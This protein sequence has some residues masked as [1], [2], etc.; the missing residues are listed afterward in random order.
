MNYDI[1]VKCKRALH[2]GPTSSGS[3]IT[4]CEYAT[5]RLTKKIKIP[6]KPNKKKMGKEAAKLILLNAYGVVIDLHSEGKTLKGLFTS[7]NFMVS[8]RTKRVALCGIEAQAYVKGDGTLDKTQFVAMVKGMY[9]D[10]LPVDIAIWLRCIEEDGHDNVVRKHIYMLHANNIFGEFSLM[11][12]S[13]L[14]M[15]ELDEDKFKRLLQR[16]CSYEGWESKKFKWCVLEGNRRYQNQN[17]DSKAGYADTK[18]GSNHKTS[19][20]GLMHELRNCWE[21]PARRYKQFLLAVMLDEYPKLL[22]DVQQALYDEGYLPQLDIENLDQL[23]TEED[24]DLE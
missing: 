20:F 12:H 7:I 22:S 2:F 21:H 16:L 19:A 8:L 10:D 23:D 5:H 1:T 4:M 17:A 11:Y 9:G 15:K 18:I 14:E 24:E 3:E 13:M 6:L